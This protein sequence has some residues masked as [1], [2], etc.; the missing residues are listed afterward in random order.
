ML[1]RKEMRREE[2]IKGK[3][4]GEKVTVEGRARSENALNVITDS[5]GKVRK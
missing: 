5:P 2:E 4:S 1:S 3:H